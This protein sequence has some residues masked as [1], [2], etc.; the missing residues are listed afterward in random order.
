MCVHTRT[1]GNLH[2]LH[3]WPILP[4]PSP[5]PHTVVA[6]VKTA[7]AAQ[8]EGQ[9]SLNPGQVIRVRQ[10][11]DD[12]WWE[13]ELQSRGQKRQVGWFPHTHVELL[14]SSKW[15][16]HP[17]PLRSISI[18][19]TV[20]GAS[21]FSTVKQEQTPSKW[22]FTTCCGGQSCLHFCSG[23]CGHKTN[24]VGKILSSYSRRF[25]QL[26]LLGWCVL[27]RAYAVPL[28]FTLSSLLLSALLYSSL[29]PVPLPSPFLL[30]HDVEGLGS[31]LALYSYTADNADELT[32]H[33]GSVITVLSK[34]AD[35]GWW[36][37]ELDNKTGLFPSNYVQALDDQL[38]LPSSRCECALVTLTTSLNP[39]SHAHVHAY[40]RMYDI[41]G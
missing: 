20:S 22:F 12:G 28:C 3:C 11:R 13:G 8:G 34:D 9:L 32:F 38:P 15:K 14:A 4:L 29:S 25:F 23:R 17:P 33:K 10:Q 18:A 26:C 30:P 37:G 27:V 2:L 7:Y 19:S 40:V 6:K 35:A 31:V 5:L 39:V 41:V 1:Q 36:H 16:E 21:V 24:F